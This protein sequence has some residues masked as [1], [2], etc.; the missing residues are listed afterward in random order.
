MTA[1]DSKEVISSNGII[2]EDS[3]RGKCC[4]DYFQKRSFLYRRV[5]FEWQYPRI[6]GLAVYAEPEIK[7]PAYFITVREITAEAFIFLMQE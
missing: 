4:I 6:K 3:L 2:G 7:L 1:I 5:I